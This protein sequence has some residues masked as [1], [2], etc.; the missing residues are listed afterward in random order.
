MIVSCLFPTALAQLAPSP[1]IPPTASIPL[2]PGTVVAG[3]SAGDFDGDGR[4]DLAWSRTGSPAQIEVLP[5]IGGGW[6]GAPARVDAG[7]QLAV[8]GSTVSAD[9]DGDGRSDLFARVNDGGIV[10]RG[11]RG[12]EAGLGLPVWTLPAIEDAATAPG[13]IDGDGID[14][15]VLGLVPY[16]GSA[17]GPVALAPLPGGFVFGGTRVWAAGDIDGD[18]TDDLWV[19]DHVPSG[20]GG[21]S[22]DGGVGLYPGS[23]LERQ[24]SWGNPGSGALALM[25]DVD[26]D[27]VRELVMFAMTRAGD[28]VTGSVFII[29]DLDAPSEIGPDLMAV[30]DPFAFDL[31]RGLALVAVGDTDGDGTEDFAWGAEGTIVA[32]TWDHAFWLAPTGVSWEHPADTSLTSLVSLHLDDD[33]RLDLVAAFSGATTSVVS[34]WLSDPGTPDETDTGTPVE[35]ADTGTPVETADT[36]DI[37]TDPPPDTDTDTG[38]DPDPECGGCRSA[39]GGRGGLPL[40]AALALGLRRQR[41]RRSKITYLSGESFSRTKSRSRRRVSSSSFHDRSS[42]R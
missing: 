12:E 36:G 9:I 5:G 2:P 16:L 11:W 33:D 40:L 42:A 29:G 27:T 26:G 39:P 30:S 7:T 1:P 14:D 21:V 4:T 10:W 31:G 24:W 25:A 8:V 35:T 15:L 13:D 19:P 34:I 18:G 17:G 28:Q 20:P 38:P 37:D 32:Y 22:P 6:L 41:F 3:I 23:S